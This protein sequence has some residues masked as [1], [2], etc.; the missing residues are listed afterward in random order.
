METLPRKLSQMELWWWE[1]PSVARWFLGSVSLATFAGVLG[2]M[3]A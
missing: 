3:L 1:I 2:G